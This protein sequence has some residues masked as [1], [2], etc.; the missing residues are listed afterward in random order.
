MLRGINP[1]VWRRLL[2]RS[3]ST[4]ADLHYTLQIAFHWSDFHLHRFLIRG[5]EYGISR[6]YCTG[7]TTDSK[8]TFLA[9][10]DFRLRERFLYEYDFCDL[11]QHQIRF[12]TTRP[13]ESKR[14]YPMCIAGARAAPPEDCGG[15]QAYMELLDRHLLNWPHE[16]FLL[17]ADALTRLLDAIDDEH[18]R[19]CLGDM[20]ELQEAVTR[21][22]AYHR[23]QPDQ[24]ARREVNRRLKQ[25]AAGD[26]E[27][28]WE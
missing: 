28:M 26:K 23:F 12:E 9:D 5:Q 25:Y 24:F 11:W 22:E 1:P 16:E 3:D 19:A 10:F 20:D 21:M 27:W 15:P 18:I 8:Q 14:T 4:I 13:V 2:L 17:I 6:A 7:F